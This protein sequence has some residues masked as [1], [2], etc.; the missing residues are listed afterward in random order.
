[1]PLFNFKIICGSLQSIAWQLP[2]FK[3]LALGT[4]IWELHEVPTKFRN[5]LL[6]FHYLKK[7]TAQNYEI[8]INLIQRAYIS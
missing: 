5:N 4:Y 2:T 1:M 6:S 7:A 3:N 8:E